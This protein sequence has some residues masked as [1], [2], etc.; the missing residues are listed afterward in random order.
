M[1][2]AIFLR[3]W[4]VSLLPQDYDEPIYLS[5]AFSYADAIQSGDFDALLAYDY[6]P[7]HPAFVKLIYGISILLL[8]KADL[9]TNAF[10]LCRI[11][12]ALF[13][14]LA[15][16]LLG[17]LVDPLAACLLAVHT[18]AIKYT[19]QVYLEAVPHALT[20]AS[21]LLLVKVKRWKS[22]PGKWFWLSSGALGIAAASKYSYIP[23]VLFV[24]SYIA[25]EN[26]IRFQWLLIYFG[27]SL[28]VF[29]TLDVSIW[30][31]PL[32][33]LSD[34][35]SFHLTYSQGV[36]VGEV[37]YPWFQ[38]FIWIFTSSPGIWH[39]NVFFYYGFDGLITIF[40][41]G[42]VR[43][44]W[45]ERRWLIV[46]AG[47]GVG[48]LM[49]WPTKWPQY[50]LTITPPL[51]IMG[52][53]SL[54]RFFA[55][56]RAHESYWDYLKEMLPKPDR[57][58]WYA[59]GA[60]ILF[61]ASIYLS[62]AI[63][64]SV[65]KIG[66]SNITVANSFLPDNTIHDLISLDDGRVLIATDNGVAIWSP[67][68]TT[69]SE[70]T[71]QIFQTTNSGLISDQV[72]SLAQDK[73]GHI[74]FGTAMGV[75]EFDGTSWVSYRAS[76]LGLSSEYVVSVF[77]S[78][79]GL[80]YAGTLTGAALLD[81]KTWLPIS[82]TEGQAVLSVTSSSDG[83][84]IW[85]GMGNGVGTY[86]RSDGSWTFMPVAAAVKHLILDS[87]NVL[88]AATSGAGLAR[89]Q[90]NK[91]VY[92]N[93]SNSEIPFNT[94]NWVLEVEP[95]LLWIGTGHPTSAEGAAASFNGTRWIVY[96]SRNSGAST[97]EVISL[98]Y[99]SEQVW[100]GTRTKG[101]DTF[102]LGSSK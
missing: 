102:R 47:L 4:A 67:A 16:F 59:V 25:F 73:A 29:F 72:L 5:N 69:D 101:I 44:E 36:H 13:G 31:D 22:K 50:A 99:H 48:F 96:G 9:W 14:I 52:A 2:L 51:C 18:L 40:A 84:T 74:W 58:F 55:W 80:F 54:R 82:Q 8:G 20:I 23:V 89:L 15:V 93:T 95:G 64:L 10:Y 88:W 7:E 46:W 94:V 90:E 66:W 86:D 12:S 38:P 6:N 87:R 30:Q 35:L 57:K 45:A 3:A 71:W 92:Y 17:I 28:F 27:F 97:G 65:G 42:G 11:V 43:R 79:D 49:A 83:G 76:D 19:S 1:L 53:E 21:I 33:R 91:W 61:T 26:K 78:P 81:E 32:G 60:F 75:A 100:M 56:A 63:K 37:G 41:L 34:S 98:L 85:L 62:A 77:A 39:P 24:L 68:K 70:P